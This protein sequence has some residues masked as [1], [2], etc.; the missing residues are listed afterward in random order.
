[1]EEFS[2]HPRAP[3]QCPYRSHQSLLQFLKVRE[4]AAPVLLES[5]PHLPQKPAPHPDSIGPLQ[6]QKCTQEPA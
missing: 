3:L 5:C 1:M 2:P 4:L 6:P